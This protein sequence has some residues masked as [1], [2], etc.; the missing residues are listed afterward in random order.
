MA[1]TS[2]APTPPSARPDEIDPELISLKRQRAGIGPI[3]AGAVIVLCGYLLVTLRHD[4]GFALGAKEAAKFGD[5]RAAYAAGKVVPDNAFVAVDARPDLANPGWLRGKLAIGYRVAP[6]LGTSGRLWIHIT[7]DSRSGPAVYDLGYSGRTRRIAE[8]AFTDE[9]RAYLATLPPAPHW[10]D[11]AALASAAGGAQVT[12]V[13]GDHVA[14][15]ADTQVELD[16]RV[17]GVALVTLYTNDTIKD[18]AGARAALVAAGFVPASTPARATDRSWTFEVP[19]ADGL[20]ALRAAISKANLYAAMASDSVADKIV[21]HAGTWKDVSVDAAAHQV[22]L[23][24][25]GTFPLDSVASLVAYV[26][27]TLPADAEILLVGERPAD[28]WY[29]LPLYGLLVVVLGLMVW[30]LVRGLRSDGPTALPYSIQAPP[31]PS[32]TE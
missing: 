22:K 19:A 30:A 20:P 8:L 3:L 28:F 13:H 24:D 32:D 29:V 1:T 31:M 16:E 4:F 6:V 10:V 11:G 14:V 2:P 26:K 7:D 18:V 5:A 27:P 12:D 25:G 17:A 9:L 23:A 21:R 15:A